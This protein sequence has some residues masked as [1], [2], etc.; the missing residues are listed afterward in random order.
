MRFVIGVQYDDHYPGADDDNPGE[1]AGAVALAL[2]EELLK[3]YG[4]ISVEVHGDTATIV[5]PPGAAVLAAGDWTYN[6]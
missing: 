4:I 2:A 5:S 3:L 1:D 6:S